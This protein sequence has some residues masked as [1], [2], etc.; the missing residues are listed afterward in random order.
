MPAPA[1]P[2]EQDQCVLA[3]I[4]VGFF[5]I[6]VRRASSGMP[7]R[8]LVKNNWNLWRVFWTHATV[9]LC[10]H[11][12]HAFHHNFTTETPQ[13]A[14]AFPQNPQEKHQSTIRN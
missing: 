8:S 9:V 7:E 2:K 11:I 10:V 14:N 13:P 1:V 5:P 6:M 12:Y 4:E 3:N